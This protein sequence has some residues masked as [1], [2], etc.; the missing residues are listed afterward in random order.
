MVYLVLGEVGH[1]E[2]DALIFLLA[3][4]NVMSMREGTSLNILARE[5]DMVSIHKKRTE[6]ERLAHCPVSSLSGG[7]AGSSLQDSLETAV[8]GDICWWDR[9]GV[10]NAL[11]SLHWNTSIGKLLSNPGSLVVLEESLPWGVEPVSE[12]EFSFRLGFGESIFADLL[13]LSDELLNV[14]I[15]DDA[16]FLEGVAVLVEDVLVLLDGLV[17][18]WLGEHGLVDLVVTVS[19]VTDQIND[20]VGIEGLSEFSGDLGDVDNGI[21]IVGVD[22]EDRGIDDSANVGTV[23]RGSRVSRISGETDL[24]VAHEMDGPTDGIERKMA[25]VKSLVDDT[26]SSES[27]VTVEKHW[28]DSFTLKRNKILNEYFYKLPRHHFCRTVRPYTFQQQWDRLLQDVMG[29]HRARR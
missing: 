19:S 3:M 10:G 20:N 28:N 11:K 9:D 26:L 23:R 13:I 29:W 14:S 6:T 12:L 24:V 17:H 5:S 4:K 21:G 18:S 25:Q 8:K 1:W 7:K 2:V 22:V 16:L 27:S 15:V